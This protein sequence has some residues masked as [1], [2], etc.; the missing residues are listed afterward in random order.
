M[1]LSDGWPRRLLDDVLG[2]L[3]L[4]PHEGAGVD[5][6]SDPATQPDRAR[7]APRRRRRCCRQTSARY[8]PPPADFDKRPHHAD[9]ELNVGLEWV[10]EALGMRWCHD[11]WSR[12][13]VR[14]H[15][16]I[17]LSYNPVI[18]CSSWESSK[19]KDMQAYA[20]V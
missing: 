2:H 14:L 11:P 5:E 1:E 17:L 13:M 20:K 7:T 8:T 18:S 16:I 10:G 19:L 4:I 9:D 6:A 12:R 3:G 15:N